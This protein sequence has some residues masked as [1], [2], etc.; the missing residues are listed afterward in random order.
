MKDALRRPARGTKLSP[1]SALCPSVCTAAGM[2]VN[3][4]QRTSVAGAAASC[5]AL[6]EVKLSALDAGSLHLGAADGERLTRWPMPYEV[7]TAVDG[8]TGTAA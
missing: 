4:A 7:P 8:E 1:L 5:V 3:A 2:V 6:I